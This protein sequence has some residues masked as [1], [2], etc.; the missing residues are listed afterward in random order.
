MRDALA[1]VLAAVLLFVAASLATTLRAYR[2]R[3]SRDR[4]G[5]QALG[6]RIIVELPTSDELVLVSEGL[7]LLLLD[8]A[9]LG[10]LLDQAL[11]RREVVQVHGV[12]QL[13]PFRRMGR[14]AWA[15]AS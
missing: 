4:E 3:R 9:A 13:N 12:A 2:R 15:A 7:D 14:A 11:G 10:G 8:E 1:G 6:R 5:Q